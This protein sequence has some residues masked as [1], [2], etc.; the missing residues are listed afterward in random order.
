MMGA[1]AAVASTSSMRLP[2]RALVC[3]NTWTMH[4]VGVITVALMVIE[5]GVLLAGVISRY[6]MHSPLIWSDELA[7]SLF[8]WM[9]MFGAVLALDRGEHMRMSALVNK[10]PEVWRGFCET[11]SALVVCLFVVMIIAP[12]MQHSHEQMWITAPAL[13]IPDG[14]R[15]AALPVGAVLMLLAAVSRMARFSTVSQFMAGIVVVAVVAAGLWISQPLLADLGNYNLIIFFLVLLGACVFGGI[16]IAF[17]FGTAT[18]AYLALATHAPLSIVVSRMDEGMS[19]MVLLAVPLFVML[20]VVLQLSGMARTLIDFM[21]SLLGHVRGGLQYVLLGAMF[22]VSG[23][24]GS[25]VADMAAVAPAL[26]PEMKK[27]G[28]KPEELA[29]LLAATGAMTET[30]PPS[31]VLITIGAVCSVSITALFIGG[32]MPAVVATVVIALVCWWRSRKDARPN[33]Q[34][35][36]LSVVVRTFM[37]ALP[38]LALPLLIRVAVLE[39]AA[40]ATE[41]ST[42]GVAYV[43]M[44]GLVMHLFMRHIEFKKVYPMML[45][46]AALSGAILL[47][48]GMASAMAWALTQSGFS[49][50]LVDVISEIPG[51]AIGFMIVTIVTFVILGSVLEGIP[52]IV[53]FG[54]LMFP[55][56]E[57]L[58]IHPV[59]YAMVVILAMGIGLFAPPLG[60]GF[61]AA[62]AISKV[63]SDHVIRRVWGYLA[64]LIVALIIVACFP[65]ISIGFL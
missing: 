58:G 64:A 52:A 11:L 57:M 54:P 29:A 39:G 59:H 9:A 63:S 36:P 13:G 62:C 20:G 25:K 40:T 50:S 38:A 6:V 31:L 4:V 61:Y 33:V 48:I 46:A 22:L 16:P 23:I 19:H 34:R 2:A 51:G 45:E 35:A 12:A 44:V 56:A 10:L 42:I 53:L 21:A 27:R 32:L 41:V 15:A 37:I 17:A 43:V 3:L 8:I 7:S 24:S 28:S 60:V 65:W 26:F 18:M 55:L 14:L 5:T 30:I 1:P 49:A 47:I